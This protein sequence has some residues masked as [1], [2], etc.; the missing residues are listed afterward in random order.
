M[1]AKKTS[2]KPAYPAKG[3][4]K[5]IPGVEYFDIQVKRGKIILTPVKITPVDNTLEAIRE[6]IK[7]PGITEKDVAY[8]VKRARKKKE[9]TIKVVFDTNVGSL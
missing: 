6:K 5:G 3:Y 2:K 4:C 9:K 1:L 8:A 7:K